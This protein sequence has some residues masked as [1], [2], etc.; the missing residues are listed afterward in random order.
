L[1]I[2]ASDVTASA[3]DGNVLGQGVEEVIACVGFGARE[4][5][6]GIAYFASESVS[7]SGVRNDM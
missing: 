6:N 5:G 7:G 1:A 3:D 2:A 4:M